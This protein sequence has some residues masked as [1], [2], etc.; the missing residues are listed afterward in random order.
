M[1]FERPFFWKKMK[2]I[3][4]NGTLVI[5]LNRTWAKDDLKMY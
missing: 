5:A 1:A 4:T 2:I 3:A